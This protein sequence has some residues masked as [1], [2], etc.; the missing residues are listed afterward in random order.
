[1][2]ASLEQEREEILDA[3]QAGWDDEDT[4]DEEYER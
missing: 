1:M 3:V 4:Y 2:T